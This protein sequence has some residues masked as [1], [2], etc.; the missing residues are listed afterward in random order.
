MHRHAKG[1]MATMIGR[2]FAFLAPGGVEFKIHSSMCIAGPVALE[3]YLHP[4]N[5]SM[6]SLEDF[7]RHGEIVGCRDANANAR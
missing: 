3:E 2:D 7:I 5:V 6:G 1:L 4:G